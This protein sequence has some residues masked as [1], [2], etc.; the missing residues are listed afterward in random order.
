MH[1]YEYMMSL[2]FALESQ[3]G[4]SCIHKIQREGLIMQTHYSLP[5]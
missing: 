2:G 5:F 4:Y 3:Q 1:I